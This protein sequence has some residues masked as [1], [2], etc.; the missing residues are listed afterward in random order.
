MPEES[1]LSVFSDGYKMNIWIRQKQ[2]E[3][4][5]QKKELCLVVAFIKSTLNRLQND[6]YIIT[7]IFKSLSKFEPTVL[8]R[9]SKDF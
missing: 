7:R 1:G 5:F 3:N 9:K 4:K 2:N 6:K 8:S